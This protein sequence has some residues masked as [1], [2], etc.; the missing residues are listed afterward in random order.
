MSNFPSDRNVR[1]PLFGPAPVGPQARFRLGVLTV[2]PLLA[3]AVMPHVAS[4]QLEPVVAKEVVVGSS[5]ASLR[6]ELTDGELEV[7]LEDGIVHVDGSEVGGFEVGGSLDAAW[8]QLL[9]SAAVMDGTSLARALV[10]WTPPGAL[11]GP[12]REVGERIDEALESALASSAFGDPPQEAEVDGELIRSLLSR[13]DRLEN[14]G[15]MLAGVDLDNMIVRIGE[16]VYVA[17]DEEVNVTLLAIDADVEIEG[18]VR[19]D[20]V[21]VD[22]T[23]TLPEEGRVTG[24]VH[25]ANSRLLSNEGVIEGSVSEIASG[26]DEESEE[27]LRDQLREEIRT[28]LRTEA[29]MD[30][31]SERSGAWNLLRPFRTI[32]RGVA[33]VLATGFNVLILCLLGWLVV[34]FAGDNVAVVAET[35]RRSPGRSAMVGLAG[36]FLVFPVWLLGTLALVLTIVGIFALPFW[37][38]LFPIAVVLAI[39]LGFYGVASGIGEHLATWRHPLVEWVRSSNPF[40]LVC[41]GLIA[42][43]T[44]FLLAHVVEMGMF[45]GM[46]EALLLV[47]GWIILVCAGLVGFGSVLITRAGRRPEFQWGRGLDEDMADWGVDPESP[48]S[49]PGG[50]DWFGAETRPGG[51]GETDPDASES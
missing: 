39:G 28:E 16:D 17:E 45:F 4:A 6:L 5:E 9:G 26:Q 41:G 3:S 8:R 49:P 22:G 7:S 25:L 27:D 32:G 30:R 14:L 40:T 20:V 34:Y 10:D 37:L 1:Y 12:E 19:G 24:D 47:A 42:L 46:I 43:A 33:G 2:L 51:H 13:T 36:T 50:D 15:D 18:T 38:V 31:A 44:P 23:L 29:T 11:Q 35:A 21:V 48:S